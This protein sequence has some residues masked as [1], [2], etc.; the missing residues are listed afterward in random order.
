LSAAIYAIRWLVRDTFRQARASGLSWVMLGVSGVC[1]L[2]C[3]SV[4]VHGTRS[5][6]RGDEP[7]EFVSPKDP[8]VDPAKAARAGVDLAGAGAAHR[9]L[10]H[11]VSVVRA[12]AAAA[13]RDLLQLLGAAGG[14]HA[15]HGG[16]CHR[17][18]AVL[19]AVLGHEL[20][21]ARRPGRTR[22]GG[23]VRVTDV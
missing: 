15:Q 18:A 1:I 16:L 9:R 14:L 20:R 17:L 13:L 19:A 10:G 5:L 6:D 12:A 3:L 4:S 11:G 7:P 21:A 8:L 22:R 23:D 2:F